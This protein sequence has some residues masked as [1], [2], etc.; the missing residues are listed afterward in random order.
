MDQGVLES[1][2]RRYRKELLA[3]WQIQLTVQNPKHTVIEFWKKLN[4]KDAMFLI[5]AAWNDIPESTLQASWRNPLLSQGTRTENPVEEQ[6]SVPELLKVLESIHGCDDC[7]EADVREWIGMECNDQGYQVL[8]DDEI[9]QTVT[10]PDT[11]NA[12]EDEEGR[13]YSFTL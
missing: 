13:S 12:M 4:I 9:V 7:D 10:E 2:K 1:T 3:F 6:P 11:S 5:A 8:N